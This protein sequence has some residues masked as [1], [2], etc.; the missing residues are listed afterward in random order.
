MIYNSTNGSYHTTTAHP[1]ILAVNQESRNEGLR[2]YKYLPISTLPPRV[3][4]YAV[5]LHPT[6]DTLY[7]PRDSRL[8]YIASAGRIGV[9][10]PTAPFFVRR[11]AVDF[12]APSEVKS[13][14]PYGV[15][16]L[17]KGLPNLEEAYLVF[18]SSLSAPDYPGHDHFQLVDPDVNRADE[19]GRLMERVFESLAYELGPKVVLE[20]GSKAESN[21]EKDGV[22]CKSGKEEGKDGEEDERYRQ[23]G[24]LASRHSP[25]DLVP[26]VPKVRLTIPHW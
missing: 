18:S 4:R 3:P 20:I 26:L 13:W 21:S 23:G 1:A 9:H 24:L 8:G 16:G 19:M 15:H 2:F 5:Y 7:F 17:I 12:I 11:V 14:D 25:N 22:E 10:L 6:H